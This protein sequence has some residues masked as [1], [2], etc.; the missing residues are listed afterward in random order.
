MAKYEKTSA[1]ETFFCLWKLF[2]KN[3]HRIHK[4]EGNSESGKWKLETR[5]SVDPAS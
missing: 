2:P 4:K 3:D 1:I 5:N